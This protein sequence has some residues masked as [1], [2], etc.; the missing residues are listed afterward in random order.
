MIKDN[1]AVVDY[2]MEQTE[3]KESITFIVQEGVANELFRKLIN[4][5]EKPCEAE[6]NYSRCELGSDAYIVSY[7]K[8]HVYGVEMLILEP[9]YVIDK[10]TDE[11]VCKMVEDDVVV[12]D[13]EIVTEE[14]LD[15]V[16]GFEE[17]SIVI[18][19]E[20]E[21]TVIKIVETEECNCDGCCECMD[22]NCNCD[23][24]DTEECCGDCEESIEEDIVDDVVEEY[25]EEMIDLYMVEDIDNLQDLCRVI[26]ETAYEDGRQTVLLGLHEDIERELER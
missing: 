7:S 13:E 15:S 16:N 25:I 3:V 10:N 24:H 14:V 8:E 11:I 1:R 6:I 9:L 22:C 23:C 21:L 18:D 5:L 4:K 12:M 20:D 26:Y 2:C 17:M 19:E